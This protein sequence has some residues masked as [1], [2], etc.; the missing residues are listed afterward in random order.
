MGVVVL[1]VT[2]P[3]DTSGTVPV[4]TGAALGLFVVAIGSTICVAVPVETETGE[5][6]AVF[7]MPLSV[8]LVL[9]PDASTVEPS[10]G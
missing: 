10:E 2:G 1:V 5:P 6:V 8:G 7:P 9:V 3:P 4:A